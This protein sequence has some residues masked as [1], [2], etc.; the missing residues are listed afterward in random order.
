MTSGWE[1]EPLGR[2]AVA[3]GRHDWFHSHTGAATTVPGSSPVVELLVT[4]R[5]TQNRSTIARGFLD[6]GSSAPSVAFEDE[7]AMIHGGLGAFDENGVSYPCAVDAGDEVWCYY[8]GWMPTS[9]TPFQN[10][11]GLARLTP[12]GTLE[13]VSRA[14]VLPR[15]DGDHLSM[16][17]CF[18]LREGARWRMWYTSF[19]AWGQAPGEPRHSYRIKYAESSDGINWR[20]DD[21]E[22]IGLTHPGE[23]SISRPTVLRRDGEYHMWFCTRGD[24][25][26]LGYARSVDGIEWDRDDG[27]AGIEPGSFHWDDRSQAYPHVFERAGAWWMIYAGNDYGAD[28]IG[29]A[30]CAAS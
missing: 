23:H 18:V 16:G 29:L 3:D 15:S 28:G 21:I 25:Y 17:S 10:H 1:W 11:I 13:R 22:A 7:P 24:E 26:R 12:A 8:T 19:I 2:I 5:D 27:A 9:M 30:R 14:P 6:L 20:R 4:V